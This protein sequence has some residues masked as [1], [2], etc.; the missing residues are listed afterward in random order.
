[1]AWVYVDDHVTEDMHGTCTCMHL[2]AP[3]ASGTTGN[4]R[5]EQRKKGPKKESVV[6]T[7]SHKPRTKTYRYKTLRLEDLP[8]D[9]QWWA[10]RQKQFPGVNLLDELD[11]A[12]DWPDAP[13]IKN[14][15]L[16]F[17]NWLSKAKPT[18]RVVRSPSLED[19]LAVL[20]AR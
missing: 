11:R 6:V 17:R 3:E 5:E 20:K 12:Q 10:A 2:H 18:L 16:F 13:R 8:S 4:D 14:A 1:M 7:G 9:S 15:K 19:Q